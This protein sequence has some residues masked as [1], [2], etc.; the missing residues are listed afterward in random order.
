MYQLVSESSPGASASVEGLIDICSLI[1]TEVEAIT[2]IGFLRNLLS[3]LRDSD[4]AIIWTG[5]YISCQLELCRPLLSD[6]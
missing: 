3:R 5:T 4:K 2:T 1:L 6:S